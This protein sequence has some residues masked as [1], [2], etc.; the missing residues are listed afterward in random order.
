MLTLTTIMK[1]FTS[2]EFI[3]LTGANALSGCTLV[4]AKATTP[5]LI[6]NTFPMTKKPDIGWIR[7]AGTFL[8]ICAGIIA[9][10]CVDKFKKFK[11]ISNLASVGMISSAV[12]IYL[13]HSFKSFA[14]LIV[15]YPMASSFR[16]CSVIVLI[17]FLS[18]VTYPCDKV[19]LISSYSFIEEVSTFGFSCAIRATLEKSNATTAIL[20]P[21]GA[22]LL[23]LCL[24]SITKP[25][26]KRMSVQEMKVN[27]NIYDE[28][29]NL[30]DSLVKH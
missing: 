11:E 22:S 23:Q 7:L 5:S 19:V 9:G 12:A 27:K 15:F 6:L 21:I 14:T 26:Y 30:L 13:G 8:T 10:Y 4:Y 24:V 18:E 29:I 3:I 20:W 2:R 17:E 28:N 16:V 25:D 1:L